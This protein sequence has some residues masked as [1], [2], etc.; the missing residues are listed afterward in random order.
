M[1]VGAA[2]VS[3]CYTF[4]VLA[5]HLKLFLILFG[6]HHRASTLYFKVTCVKS[7][8]SKSFEPF[9]E[10]QRILSYMQ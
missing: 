6:T 1:D 2:A 5:M 10:K 3:C 8:F 9:G 7:V 4:H